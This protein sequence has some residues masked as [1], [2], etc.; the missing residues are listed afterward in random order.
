MNGKKG[1]PIFSA[2][3][4]LDITFAGDCDSNIYLSAWG[5]YWQR[6][7]VMVH[8]GGMAEAPI[9]INNRQL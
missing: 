7:I 1:I 3:S 9:F 4:C 6:G 5:G 8:M 2:P